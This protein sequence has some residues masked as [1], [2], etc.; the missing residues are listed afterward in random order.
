[1]N[2][3][4]KIAL[5]GDET[6]TTPALV[7]AAA[8]LG[9]GVER[10]RITHDRG[11]GRPP[12]DGAVIDLDGEREDWGRSM[13]LVRSVARARVPILAVGSHLTRAAVEELFA[14]GVRDVIAAPTH[15]RELILRLS[16]LLHRKLRVACIGGGSG[17]FA[18][19]S[20]LK[21]LSRVLLSS[22]VTMS[23]DGGS[24]GLLRASFG[25][26]PPGDIRRSLVALS[27][28]PEVMSYVMQY[29]FTTGDGLR[30]HSLGN[31]LLTALSELTGGMPSAVKALGDLLN[32]QGLVMCV[33]D[34]A[35]TLCAEFEDG[36]IV[37]GE[38][39]IDRCLERPAGL[40]IKGVWQ[41]PSTETSIDVFASIVG[42]DLIVIGPGDLYTSVLAG[43]IVGGVV[44]AVRAS[45]AKRLYV[46]NL[47]TKPGETDGY[48][49]ADHVAPLVRTLG[50]DVL[51]Y[52][53]V[54]C[55][56]IEPEAESAYA[57]QGQRPVARSSPE[58]FRAITKAELI[59]G[60]IGD[61]AR[62]VRHDSVKLR[63][64]LG[65]ILK[66]HRPSL[67]APGEGA[68]E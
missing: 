50:Q 64:E 8:A 11:S 30:G 45:G 20:A 21:E 5:L 15:K 3:S 39:A 33:T 16:A 60:D 26:L 51:D 65:A 25:I 66:R 17:L 58:K 27:N 57:A 7:E 31:L 28:A 32:V 22:I 19:L 13:E 4:M 48:D 46:C 35:S 49:V 55:T 37:Q 29:R 1:M 12:A 56:A 6:A 36:R 54:S 47:M 40:R 68:E 42:A 34:Q 43:L 18:V 59:S 63:A 61:R 62:L 44:E 10:G 67:F 14:A 53:L 2:E 23:D 52:V 9:V 38:S 41:E 24:S